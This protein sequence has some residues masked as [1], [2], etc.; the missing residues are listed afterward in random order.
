MASAIVYLTAQRDVFLIEGT[1]T[2]IHNS[3]ILLIKFCFY[4]HIC[5][6]NYYVYH[7]YYVYYIDHQ[8]L[9][10]RRMLLYTSIHIY[11]VTCMCIYIRAVIVIV[12]LSITLVQYNNQVW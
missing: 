10:L 9:I 8:I 12:C 1:H 7:F 11:M 5:N 4:I 3:I 6:Y 2:H